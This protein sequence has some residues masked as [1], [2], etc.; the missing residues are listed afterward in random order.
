MIGGPSSLDLM[1]A[2]LASL[3]TRFIGDSLQALI[4][5]LQPSRFRSL[6]LGRAVL[7]GHPVDVASGRM[8]TRAV[9][10]EL[11]GPLPLK[12]ERYY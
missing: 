10:A 2:I 8:M 12:I 6:L 5:R 11:P 1:A 9:D 7:T 3:R 4:S